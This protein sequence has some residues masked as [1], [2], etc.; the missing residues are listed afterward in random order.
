MATLSD[1]AWSLSRL[2]VSSKTD[3]E[4]MAWRGER[5]LVYEFII[6]GLSSNLYR[7]RAVSI[8][9]RSFLDSLAHRL[10]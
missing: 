1:E 6:H 9:S 2:P 8:I 7:R 10:M 3:G 4:R 5:K